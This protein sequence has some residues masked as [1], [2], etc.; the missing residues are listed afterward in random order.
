M[1]L[2]SW[3]GVGQSGSPIRVRGRGFE[4]LGVVVVI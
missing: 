4:P 2:Y 3:A 1:I